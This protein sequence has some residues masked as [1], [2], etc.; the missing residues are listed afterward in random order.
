MILLKT[1][2]NPG[3]IMR[4]IDARENAVVALYNPGVAAGIG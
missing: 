2:P 1:F 3:A 4:L